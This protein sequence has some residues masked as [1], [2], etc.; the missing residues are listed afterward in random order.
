VKKWE[1]KFLLYHESYNG[2]DH[3]DG[4][5]SYNVEARNWESATKK[6]RKLVRSCYSI[7]N[8][9]VSEKLVKHE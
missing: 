4:W 5:E 7:R 8:T 9:C 6:A 2:Y 3:C 1:V